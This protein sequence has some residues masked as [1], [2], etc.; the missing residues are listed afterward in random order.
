VQFTVT[1]DFV[2]QPVYVLE[3]SGIPPFP[4]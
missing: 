4:A 3:S 1:N 2:D